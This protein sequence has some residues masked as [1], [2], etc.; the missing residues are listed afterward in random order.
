MDIWVHFALIHPKGDSDTTNRD[1]PRRPGEPETEQPGNQHR[2][3][4]WGG[5]GGGVRL[6]D[7]YTTMSGMNRIILD[8]K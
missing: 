4:G 7:D 1:R 6:D 2:G 3:M 8:S 5:G